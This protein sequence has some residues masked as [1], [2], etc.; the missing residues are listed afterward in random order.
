MNEQTVRRF[1]VLTATYLSTQPLLRLAR[2]LGRW[3]WDRRKVGERFVGR[4]NSRT[5]G[6]Y[7]N[8]F[9]LY[10]NS[11]QGITLRTCLPKTVTPNGP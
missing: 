3:R 7:G 2:M 10:N 6:L 11:L 1:A 5:L 8:A 9:P 4:S